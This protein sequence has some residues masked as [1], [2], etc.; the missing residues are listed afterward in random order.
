[1]NALSTIDDAQTLGQSSIAGSHPAG[2]DP[3]GTPNFD[4]LLSEINKLTQV[5]G[6][7][8]DWAVVIAKATCVLTEQA[9]DLRA[10]AYLAR[11]LL[12]SQGLPGLSKGI[13][14][15]AAIVEAHW[16][17]C[18]PPKKRARGRAAALVWFAEKVAPPLRARFVDGTDGPILATLRAQVQALDTDLS[19]RMGD[20]APDLSDLLGVLSDKLRTAEAGDETAGGPTDGSGPHQAASHGS[21]ATPSPPTPPASAALPTLP[22]LDPSS[23]RVV[24]QI[25]T[26]ASAA[27]RRQDLGNPLFYHMVRYATWRSISEAP[28]SSGGKT[29]L[30]PVPVDRVAQY[31]KMLN[32][33]HYEDLIAGTEQSIAR[34]PFW[35]S[36]QRLTDRALAELGHHA[37]RRA[38]HYEVR[39]FIERVPAVLT[40]Q[41]S[42]GTPFVD[43]PTKD[44]LTDT[45]LAPPPQAPSA[46]PVP[47]QGGGDWRAMLVDARSDA[48]PD[49]LPDLLRR[50]DAALRTESEPRRC[51]LWRM[52][53][54]HA[55]LEGGLQAMALTQFDYLDGVFLTLGL[56]AWEPS[57]GADLTAARQA[58][59]G[60]TPLPSTTI[61][62]IPTPLDKD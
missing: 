22:V 23:D 21:A 37:A 35:L 18:W 27:L 25:F 2:T 8:V 54:A 9:K 39:Q 28:P 34:N 14:T 43:A 57:L 62:P 45:V 11:G 1:M 56:G 48:L 33:R 60:A 16:D 13:A 53:Q 24:K 46:S 59:R 40:L 51:F 30:A 4:A 6:P 47:P 50:L 12:E 15:L 36:G 29:L 41:F 58:C 7:S 44:W 17:S 38:V 19:D 20:L 31:E 42:D 61:H 10:G 49:D 32:S 52:A 55:C 3:D 26:E 5:G